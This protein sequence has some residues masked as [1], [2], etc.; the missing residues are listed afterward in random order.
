MSNVTIKLNYKNNN[1]NIEILNEGVPLSIIHHDLTEVINSMAKKLISEAN[2]MEV[3]K[4]KTKEYIAARL[5]V[6]M[7]NFYNF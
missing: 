7:N 5:K 2:E 6:D 1:C 4:E 3:P